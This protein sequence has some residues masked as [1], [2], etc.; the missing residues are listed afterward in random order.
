MRDVL[1]N[2][3]HPY[4]K[5]LPASA[6]SADPVAERRRRTAPL[7]GEVPSQLHPPSGRVFRTRCPWAAEQ[8]A[9]TV[10]PPVPPPL[11]PDAAPESRQ[12]SREH[13]AA[14]IRLPVVQASSRAAGPAP[15][16]SRTGSTRTAPWAR[17]AA[18]TDADPARSRAHQEET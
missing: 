10:S 11:A 9:R 8:C 12:T 1:E 6:P 5:A 16:A 17:H 15:A 13:L 7:E 4:T 18:A 2:P 3:A 14:C